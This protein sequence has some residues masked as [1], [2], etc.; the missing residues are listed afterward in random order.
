MQRLPNPYLIDF[1]THGTEGGEQ[2]NAQA[3]G[4]AARQRQNQQTVH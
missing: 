2:D 1:H 3:G 4:S